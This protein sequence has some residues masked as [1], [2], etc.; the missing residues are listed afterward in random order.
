MKVLMA[1]LNNSHYHNAE[2]INVEM[3]IKH[4]TWKKITASNMGFLKWL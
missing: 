2:K 4:K 1:L 3:Q